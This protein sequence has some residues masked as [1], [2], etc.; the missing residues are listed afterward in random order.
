MLV[1]VMVTRDLMAVQAPPLL[2]AAQYLAW[3][4]GNLEKHEVFN[5]ELR[6]VAGANRRHIGIV[7]N[8]ATCLGERI[9]EA[10][11]SVL[12]AG[13]K[14]KSAGSRGIHY[15][16]PD[17]CVVCGEERYESASQ[18]V[19]LNPGLVVEVTS[20]S[21]ADYDRGEKLDI[22]FDLPSIEACLIIDQFRPR[23]EL[24]QRG[25]LDWDLESFD[26]LDDSVPLQSLACQLPLARIYRGIVFDQS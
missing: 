19:L 2:T 7:W 18:L 21:T 13:M 10:R 8:T 11:C 3:E 25:R 12:I 5:G 26:S 15:L 14:V 23:V 22:T 17:I 16:Y 9:D 24:F 20:R 1:K 4:A 6:C